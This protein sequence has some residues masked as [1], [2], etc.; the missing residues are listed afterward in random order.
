MSHHLI[1]AETLDPSG[2]SI[3]LAPAISVLIFAS[4]VVS[5]P[6]TGEY[7]DLPNSTLWW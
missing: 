4:M 3:D 2:K 1:R 7:V 6:A 5:V